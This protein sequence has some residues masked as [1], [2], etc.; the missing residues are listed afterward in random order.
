MNFN[1]WLNFT[2]SCNSEFI[3]LNSEKKKP[4]KKPTL[5]RKLNSENSVKLQYVNSKSQILSLITQF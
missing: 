4:E 3:F 5:R 1:K 2:F